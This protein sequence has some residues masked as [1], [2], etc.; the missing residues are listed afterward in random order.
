MG[1]VLKLLD[2]VTSA[3]S[4]PAIDLHDVHSRFTVVRYF[5]GTVTVL[6]ASLQGSHDGVHW[7]SLVAA[8][9]TPA[10]GSTH[11]VRYLRGHIESYTGT[12]PVT[13][14]VAVGD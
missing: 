8:D 4:G 11:Q 10:T 3:G 13:M 9:S 2:G 5:T 1:F 12:G 7:F 14:T 6:Q